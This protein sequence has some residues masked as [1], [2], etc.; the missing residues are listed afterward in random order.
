MRPIDADALSAFV[1]DLRSTLFKEQG[2]F[3]AMTP[4]EFDTRD[5]MLL[6]F[7][8]VIDN[9]PPVEVPEDKVNCVLTL[10]GKCSYNETGCS[11]CEIKDKIHKA[12]NDRP[13][14]EWL[15][16]SGNIACSHCHT[17]WL[18]RRTDFCPHCGADMRE[19]ESE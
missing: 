15:E 3:K 2:T 17:I 19:E 16:D 11:D 7:Q 14:G 8:Q 9:A 13:T 18:Y 5:H 1:G 10:F 12:L 4:I 6:N